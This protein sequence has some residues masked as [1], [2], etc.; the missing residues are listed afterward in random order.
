[1]IVCRKSRKNTSPCGLP[2]AAM[3][4]VPIPVQGRRAVAKPS[5]LFTPASRDAVP[6]GQNSTGTVGT[7]RLTCGVCKCVLLVG[8]DGCEVRLCG[9]C[10]FVRPRVPNVPCV[11]APPGVFLPVQYVECSTSLIIPCLHLVLD[12][13]S[14]CFLSRHGMRDKQALNRRARG[15]EHFGRRRSGRGRGRPSESDP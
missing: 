4:C 2:R 14:W 5:N 10:A 11:P 3:A 13:L 6:L 7:V 9:P 1:M 8:L 12:F 15:G